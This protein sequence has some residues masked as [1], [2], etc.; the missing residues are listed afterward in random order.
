[1]KKNWKDD[2]MLLREASYEEYPDYSDA[3]YKIILTYNTKEERDKIFDWLKGISNEEMI[4]LRKIDDDKI[5]VI[6]YISISFKDNENEDI[7]K[8][9]EEIAEETD[10][11][12]TEIE[13]TSYEEYHDTFIEKKERRN[14]REAHSVGG[15][16]SLIITFESEYDR[17]KAYK[18][19]KNTELKPVL[20]EQAIEYA[21]Y[22]PRRLEKAADSREALLV[23]YMSDRTSASEAVIEFLDK[24]ENE[25]PKILN[26][27]DEENF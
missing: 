20:L 23:N 9:V 5:K 21:D 13:E 18:K 24:F 7:E 8:W 22:V 3:Y 12:S 2:N 15:D 26:I 17:W 11:V 10:A 14:I 4:T 16:Y 27:W 19:L 25:L 1:M 6:K